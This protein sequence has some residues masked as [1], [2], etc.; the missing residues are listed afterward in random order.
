MTE[1]T[2]D[3]G[4]VHGAIGDEATM[5]GCEWC[6]GSG[7]LTIMEWARMNG[8]EYDGIVCEYDMNHGWYQLDENDTVYYIDLDFERFEV[9]KKATPETITN[10]LNEE[11]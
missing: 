4:T 11:R 2:C 10:L 1:C 3:K 6:N 7:T 5:E 9:L 8:W